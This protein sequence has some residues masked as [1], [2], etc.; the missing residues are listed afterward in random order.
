M[1]CDGR[2]IL[3]VLPTPWRSSLTERSCTLFSWPGA[4][5]HCRSGSSPLRRFPRSS[6]NS[7]SAPAAT[8]RPRASS[9]GPAAIS[10]Y[11]LAV[12]VSAASEQ[13]QVRA[14]TAALAGSALARRRANSRSSCSEQR[15]CGEGASAEGRSRRLCS[16]SVYAL[17]ILPD[18]DGEEA[19]RTGGSLSSA[20]RIAF[21]SYGLARYATVGRAVHLGAR[22]RF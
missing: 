14:R 6:R 10:S 16:S 21:G 13:R 11:R 12:A 20:A 15:S 5:R 17:A 3:R 2:D 7:T 19:G 1:T 22:A 9:P 8:S 4:R 18:E